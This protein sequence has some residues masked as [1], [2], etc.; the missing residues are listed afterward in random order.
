VGMGYSRQ[1]VAIGLEMLA[2]IV[3]Q[4][5][6]TLQ[7][8]ALIA[9]ASTFHRTVLILLILPAFSF[10]GKLRYSK[11]IRFILLA[12]A[13]YGLYSAY[14]APSLDYYF[15]SYMENE[16][17]AEG[18]MIRVALCF[19]PAII[20][21][22]NRR[23]FRLSTTLLSIWTVLSWITIASAFILFVLSSTMVVDRLSLYLIPLQ[24]FVSSRL[25]ETRLLGISP[26]LWNQMLIFLSLL[27]MLV[28]LLFANHAYAWIPYRNLLLSL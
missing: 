15:S 18:A 24:L 27:V 7:Y 10:S 25:P 17:K 5:D 8:I 16:F 3:L 22:W 4:R 1:G 23:A 28:W 19:L 11:L 9:L 13:S 20:F 12:G 14:I 21:L 2:L 6:R 26:P